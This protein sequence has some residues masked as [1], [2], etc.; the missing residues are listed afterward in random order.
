MLH[1]D[2]PW[3]LVLALLV[4]AAWWAHLRF[5]SRRLSV[6][7]SYELEETLR[8]P[9]G[10]RIMLRRIGSGSSAQPPVL[11]VHGIAVN[12]RNND[13]LPERS[14]AR[15]L[16]EQGRDVWLLTLR[17][18]SGARTLRSRAAFKAMRDHD[19]PRAVAEVLSRTGHSQLDLCCYS[20][21]GMVLYAALGRTLDPAQVRRVVAFA[22][23]GQVRPLGIL[24]LARFI[25]R[26]LT[27]PV[28][29]RL[30]TR[31]LAFAHHL[32]PRTSLDFF[33]NPTNVPAHYARVSMMDLFEDIPGPLGADFVRWSAD[34][35][36]VTV[37][38]ELVLEGL[39]AVNVP[40]CFFA[41]T[42]D[43]L[44]PAELVRAAH[45]AWG[46]DHPDVEKQFFVREDYG[47]GDFALGSAALEDVYVPALAFL[48][49]TTSVQRLPAFGSSL[50]AP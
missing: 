11:L 37:D 39:R 24:N 7:L 4:L 21:G 6:Q 12:H 34:R 20:M 23:P 32:L 43:L 47:H 2:V 15:F 41:G 10:G 36:R 3:L 31:S 29:M 1:Q 18:G 40:A 5:W 8:M 26:A 30:V 38:G 50:P 25:P 27:P 35:G 9:D 16:A 33:Y 45:D 17:S 13:L 42:R 44:A 48:D 28:P 19:L 22:S 49:T 46:R 14:F